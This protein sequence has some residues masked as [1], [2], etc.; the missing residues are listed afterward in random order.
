MSNPTIKQAVEL[1]RESERRIQESISSGLRTMR[2]AGLVV[3]AVNVHMVNVQYGGDAY[4]TVV[5]ERVELD[6]SL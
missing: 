1:K 3:R 5:V 2:E 6:V 4:P